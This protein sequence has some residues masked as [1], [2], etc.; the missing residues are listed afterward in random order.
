VEEDPETILPI[1]SGEDE[2]DNGEEEASQDDEGGRRW[3]S[4]SV[5]SSSVTLQPVTDYKPQQPLQMV[6]EKTSPQ[7]N[8]A[9]QYMHQP[10]HQ[11]QQQQQSQI[12][13]RMPSSS[14]E[15]SYARNLEESEAEIELASESRHPHDL[16]MHQTMTQ[17]DQL[18]S[19]I[20]D[21]R[22]E[23]L[24]MYKTLTGQVN[25]A[26]SLINVQRSRIEF[27]ETSLHN[28]KLKEHPAH[29]PGFIDTNPFP[30]DYIIEQSTVGTET[31]TTPLYPTSSTSS[32]NRIHTTFLAN[33]SAYSPRMGQPGY[34]VFLSPSVE[35]DLRLASPCSNDKSMWLSTTFQGESMMTNE[36]SLENTSRFDQNSKY[37]HPFYFIFF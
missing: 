7:L 13:A 1:C 27:L 31:P 34:N 25:K 9:Q 4:S 33:N 14:E 21:L 2:S 35:D 23:Y 10:L 6:F 15:S 20:D 5:S 32:C 22:R 24:K 29:H 36:T 26:S 28:V 11:Q 16:A 12:L 17:E 19:Q 3:S 8:M 30:L 18:R 37:I